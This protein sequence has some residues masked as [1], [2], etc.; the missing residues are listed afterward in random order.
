M[1]RMLLCFALIVLSM[2]ASLGGDGASGNSGPAHFDRIRVLLIGCTVYPNLDR[3]LWLQGPANDVR[4]LRDVLL[5]YPWDVNPD[6]I[7]VLTGWPDD[8]RTRPTRANILRYLK[9]LGEH[10]LPGEAVILYFAGHGSRQPAGAESN[11]PDGMDEIFLPADCNAF[12]MSSGEVDG[13]LSDKELATCVERMRRRGACV[14]VFFDACHSGGL[15]R[16][17]F[18]ACEATRGIEP[19][20]LGI[21]FDF[22]GGTVFRGKPADAR[23]RNTSQG[24]RY[25]GL[26]EEDA[27]GTIAWLSAVGSGA[28]QLAKERIF[29]EAGNSWHGV[30]SYLVAAWLAN[31]NA[32]FSFRELRDHIGYQYKRR[33]MYSLVPLV[34]GDTGVDAL[35]LG[36][37]GTSRAANWRVRG[38]VWDREAWVLDAGHLHGVHLGDRFETLDDSGAQVLL[39]IDKVD[40]MTSE[41]IPVDTSGNTAA[42]PG[43]IQAGSRL[44]RVGIGRKSALTLSATEL[45][46]DWASALRDVQLPE[47]WVW[48]APGVI[49]DW[50]LELRGDG[51]WLR[52]FGVARGGDFWL[53]AIDDGNAPPG[54]PESLHRIGRALDL[55]DMRTIAGSPDNPGI[56]VS[57]LLK[58]HRSESD[59]AGEPWDGIPGDGIPADTI[60]SLDVAN[61]EKS[62]AIDVWVFYLGADATVTLIPWATPQAEPGRI[63]PGQAQTTGRWRV[64]KDVERGLDTLLVLALSARE[65]RPDFSLWTREE[66]STRSRV[67]LSPLEAVFDKAVTRGG[68]DGIHVAAFSWWVSGR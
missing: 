24:V 41:V 58:T 52:S 8:A 30:F 50:T 22:V 57:S 6:D 23:N 4:L 48:S 16:S 34:D 54:W 44:C 60:M 46:L 33:G 21:P 25:S 27:G 49:A 3:K 28:D 5:A 26:W 68:D 9:E 12:D 53:G 56:K 29:P 61:L 37:Q 31:S 63:G 19:S 40:L 32:P 2:N 67:V 15:S 66:E 47:P 17:D 36:E 62:T 39:R 45:P 43:G 20:E 7:V 18:P 1:R 35:F 13:S 42:K 14:W 11:E 38:K 59:M 10:C 65:P 64:K 55:L 51:W